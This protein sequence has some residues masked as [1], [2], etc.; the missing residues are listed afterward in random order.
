MHEWALAESVVASITTELKDRKGASLRAVN[1]LFGELQNIDRAIFE[2][3][4]AEM[5]ADVPHGE[6]SVHIRIDPARFT[7]NVC[8]HEWGL[9]EV[10]GLT[11]EQ[12]E[13]IHFL[14]EAAHAFLHCPSCNSSDCQVT[15]GRGIALTS[16]EL[17]E[18]RDAED[19]R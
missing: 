14:P 17:I 9:D 19:E 16:I 11:E 10:G 6:D 13:A 12:R 18:P 2:E 15:Q 7:C 1:L 3:A 8:A 5:L 4:L